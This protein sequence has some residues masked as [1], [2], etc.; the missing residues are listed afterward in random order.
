MGE[1]LAAGTATDAA[2]AL[3]H[4]LA[5]DPKWEVRGA[6]ADLLPVVPDDDFDRLVARLATDSNTYVRRSV[7]RALERRRKDDRANG[8][9][10]RSAD[11]VNQHLQAIESDYGKPAANKALRMC[12]RYSELLV[13]SMVHDL[14]SILTHLK[15]NCYSLIEE[16]AG[17]SGAKVRRT[18]ARV[19]S[20]L[21]FLEMAIQD[22]NAFTQPRAH[23]PATGAAGGRGS[24]RPG[25][26]PRQRA[27]GETR[28][29]HRDRP[30]RRSR[31]DRRRDREAPD[32]HGAG[33]RPEERVRGIRRAAASCA[34]GGS[35]SSPPWRATT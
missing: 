24:R 4:Q 23:R 6:I 11:Q 18:G 16:V 25:P 22:M 26:G 14:R 34:K 9:E 19:R 13:G 1:A 3:A 31:V 32:R 33:Q 29:G 15:T 27:E 5:A 28:S 12:Q 35:G 8:Q 21:E 20:D 7:E 30:G 17:E 2:L 10:R